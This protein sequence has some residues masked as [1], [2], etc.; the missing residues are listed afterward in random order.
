LAQ[1][2]YLPSHLVDRRL[3]EL[4]IMWIHLRHHPPR[5][6]HEGMMIAAVPREVAG[7]RSVLAALLRRQAGV[8]VDWI[9]NAKAEQPAVKIARRFRIHHVNA[10]MAQA[11]KLERPREAHAADIELLSNA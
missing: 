5:K 4:P 3:G 2:R 11:Q 10:E 6:D 7:A 8:H 9:G 1:A